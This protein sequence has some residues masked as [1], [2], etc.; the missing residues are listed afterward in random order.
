MVNQ[1]V[2]H[3][4]TALVIA[5]HTRNVLQLNKSASPV[6]LRTIQIASQLTNAMTPIVRA[7]AQ[8]QQQCTSVRQIWKHVMSV[9]R[10]NQIVR[11]RNNV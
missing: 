1:D 4:Q 11:L 8:H 5:N 7:Q 6:T 10:A 2:S 9:I 3:N